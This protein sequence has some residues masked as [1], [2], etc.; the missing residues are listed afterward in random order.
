[1]AKATTAD[2]LRGVS[3]AELDAKVI[4]LKEELFT[5]RFQHQTG[6]LESHGRLR[7]VRKDIARIYTVIQ[8]RVLGI[9]PDPDEGKN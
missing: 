1:M 8:E 9:V 5:L 2:D 3:R 7:D 4:E 6:Q